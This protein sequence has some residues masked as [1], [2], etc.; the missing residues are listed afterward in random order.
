MT[1]ATVGTDLLEALEVL[2]QLHVE[3]VGDDL[4]ELAVLHVLL[5][6]QHPVRHLEL[7]R[8]LDDRHQTLN[9]LLGQLTRTAQAAPHGARRWSPMAPAAACREVVNT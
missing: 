7:A 4:R 2:A 3:R 6:V 5:P 9:L 8:V 1:Q